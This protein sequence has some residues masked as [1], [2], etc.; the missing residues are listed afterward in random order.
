M[1][2]GFG[3]RFTPKGAASIATLRRR[4][5][6]AGL[7]QEVFKHG[8]VELLVAEIIRARAVRSAGQKAYREYTADR[9][10]IVAGDDVQVGVEL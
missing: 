8:L 7:P 4:H 3:I 6:G 2:L 1:V 9:R 5:R 10:A